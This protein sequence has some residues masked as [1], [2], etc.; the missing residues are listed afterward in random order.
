MSVSNVERI[1]SEIE[2]A[3]NIIVTPHIMRHTFAT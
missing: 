3:T 1:F 2:A